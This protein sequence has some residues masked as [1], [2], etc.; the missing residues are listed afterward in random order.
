MCKCRRGNIIFVNIIAIS[1]YHDI[2]LQ[3]SIN[4]NTP[5]YKI[6]SMP[7]SSSLCSIPI[8]SYFKLLFKTAITCT[9]C[10]SS[11]V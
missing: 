10:K 1:E 3:I 11:E 8:L 6:C 5:G 9:K 2:D 7:I 4:A